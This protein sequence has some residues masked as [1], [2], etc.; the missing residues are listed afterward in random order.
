LL[1]LGGRW[2][3]FSVVRNLLRRRRRRKRRRHELHLLLVV[4]VRWIRIRRIWIW[5]NKKRRLLLLHHLLLTI[6]FISNG[7]PT[8]TM[9]TIT[10]W[11]ER[12]RLLLLLLL[13]HDFCVED[14]RAL[15][16]ATF[17]KTFRVSKWD[18]KY[19]VLERKRGQ[20]SSIFTRIYTHSRDKMVRPSFFFPRLSTT[21]TT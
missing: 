3:W 4:L 8:T 20:N 14:M 19:G 12:R 1:L 5:R 10:V 17:E 21:T 15:L 9:N 16:E 13:L 11:C 2:W 7:T 18:P 6:S